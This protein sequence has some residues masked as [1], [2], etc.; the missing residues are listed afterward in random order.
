[1]IKSLRE[2]KGYG[3]THFLREFSTKNWTRRGLDNLL[4]KTDPLDRLIVWRGM[5]IKHA[6]PSLSW[7]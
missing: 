2:L 7:I 3:S 5:V 6:T 1:L 4:V